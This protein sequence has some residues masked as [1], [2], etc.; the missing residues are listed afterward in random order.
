M[1]P[2]AHNND[3]HEGDAYIRNRH[4]TAVA[5]LA[6]TLA[7]YRTA[8]SPTARTMSPFTFESAG[9]RGWCGALIFCSC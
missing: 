7:S 4:S 9:H 2:D 5:A 1:Q 8:K 6:A 3:H